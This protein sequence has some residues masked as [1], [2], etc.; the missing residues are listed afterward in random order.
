MRAAADECS[1]A[2][3]N[4]FA[5]VESTFGD[6]RELLVFTT[7]LTARKACARFIARFGSEAYDEHSKRLMVD[8]RRTDLMAQ[9]DELEL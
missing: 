1:A 9:I 6:G 7:E 8:E 2:L 5:F 3:G 4:A